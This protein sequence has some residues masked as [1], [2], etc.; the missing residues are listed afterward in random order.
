M[1]AANR[2][3]PAWPALLVYVMHLVCKK[4]SYFKKR[5][6]EESVIEYETAGIT[7]NVGSAAAVASRR[8]G[9]FPRSQVGRRHGHLLDQPWNPVIASHPARPWRSST[10]WTSTTCAGCLTTL[11]RTILASSRRR[12]ARAALTKIGSKCK[13]EDLDNDGHNKISLVSSL[14]F[15]Q[16]IG[17]HTHPIFKGWSTN[18]DTSGASKTGQGVFTGEAHLN[19]VFMETQQACS[20]LSA[21]SKF[22][23]KSLR[24][25]FVK[26]DIDGDGHLDLGEIRLAIKNVA[27]QITQMEISLMLATSDKDQDGKITF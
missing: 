17:K 8:S 25:A 23:E 15:S 16:L 26:I 5:R 7:I 12:I 20:K 27:P 9:R 13:M 6:K 10:P 14:V 24:K 18:T 21:T 2:G 19:E 22:D 3:D 11:T 1:A 4:Q